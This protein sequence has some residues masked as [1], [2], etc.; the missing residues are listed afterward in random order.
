MVN[1]RIQSF[2]K[3]H[4]FETVS[5]SSDGREYILNHGTFYVLNDS[6]IVTYHTGSDGELIDLANTYHF[7]IKDERMH[8]YGFYLSQNSNNLNSIV[9]VRIDEIWEKVKK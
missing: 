7:R 2:N 9:K 5:M 1:S 6:T 3:D 4:S 8:F